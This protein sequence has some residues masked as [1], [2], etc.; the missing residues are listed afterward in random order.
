MET[1]QMI[2]RLNPLFKMLDFKT[3][4]TLNNRDFKTLAHNFFIKMDKLKD[5]GLSLNDD[6]KN[7]INNKHIEYYDYYESNSI[8]EERMQNI[9]SEL[10][11]FCPPPKFWSAPF[12]EYLAYKW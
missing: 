6:F 4:S 3:V 1:N 9:L 8:Y 10:I 7:F 11:E 12:D 5:G 2:N